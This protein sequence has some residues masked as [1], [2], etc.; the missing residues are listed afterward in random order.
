M[1]LFRTKKNLQT[2]LRSI[3]SGN[4][5]LGMVPTMGALHKGHLKLVRQAV[6]ENDTVVVSIFVNPTQFDKTEDLKKY[7]KTLL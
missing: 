6:L 4:S 3:S 2:H 7:P 1:L 5:S